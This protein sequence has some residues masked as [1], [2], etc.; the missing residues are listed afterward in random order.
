MGQAGD[1]VV[2]L[3]VEEDLCL[4]LEPAEGLGMV[5][6][7]AIAL[8]RRAD[9]VRSFLDRATTTVRGAGRAG[10]EE[11]ALPPLAILAG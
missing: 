9:G 5:D 3:G 1:E 7:V 2:S 6:A 10:S 11:L 8:E 4:V